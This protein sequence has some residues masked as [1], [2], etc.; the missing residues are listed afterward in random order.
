MPTKV[1][2][3]YDPLNIRHL[4]KIDQMIATLSQA[5]THL[6]AVAGHLPPDAS[7]TS[8]KLARLTAQ[9]EVI[10]RR[11]TELWSHLSQDENNLQNCRLMVAG[12]VH[13][14]VEISIGRA[15]MMVERPYENVLFRLCYNDI[16]VEPLPAK[17]AQ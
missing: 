2:L 13:P 12:V 10:M 1:Y 5:I 4:E 6:K 9:R 17:A 8:R 3:G 15:F 14:G 11:R 16:V 7:E